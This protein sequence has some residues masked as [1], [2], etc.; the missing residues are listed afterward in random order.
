MPCAESAHFGL[1]VGTRCLLRCS[2]SMSSSNVRLRESKESC[3]IVRRGHVTQHGHGT[4]GTQ[5]K[6]SYDRKICLSGLA[7]T[8]THVVN[9]LI[10]VVARTSPPSDTE[11]M[12]DAPDAAVFSGSVSLP[13]VWRSAAGN[14]KGVNVAI[15]NDSRRRVDQA[16]VTACGPRLPLHQ[17]A[18]HA[19]HLPSKPEFWFAGSAAQAAGS[20][21]LLKAWL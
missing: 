19:L 8:A 20:N 10:I 15:Q 3:G 13:A 11:S 7:Y 1:T 18:R 4:N 17:A 21:Q 6:G 16:N 2:M 14:Q 12:A 9:Q 5:T